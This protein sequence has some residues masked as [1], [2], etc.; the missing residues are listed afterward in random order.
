M[1]EKHKSTREEVAVLEVGHTDVSRPVT[2]WLTL[3]FLAVIALIPL[4]D[5][6]ADMF[7][8]AEGLRIPVAAEIARIAPKMTDVQQALEKHG[9]FKGALRINVRLL[10]G[11]S[12]YESALKDRSLFANTIIPP[13]Q[14]VLIGW[15]QAGSE[16]VYCGH[17]GWLF[18]RPALDSLTGRGFLDP[19]VL[20]TRARPGRLNEPIQPDPVKAIVEFRDYLKARDIRLV[21]LPAPSKATV[22]PE[23]FSSRYDGTRQV[24]NVS[25]GLFLNRLEKA[26]VDVFDPVPLLV[27]AKAEGGVPF[28]LE[29]DTHWSPAGMALT[30]R[31]LARYLN[32]RG[33][34]P[35][36]VKKEYTR[37]AREI[38]HKGDIAAMLR[39]EGDSPYVQPETVTIQRVLEGDGTPWRAEKDAEILVLGDSFTNVFSLEAMGWGDDAGLAP[40]LAAELG[41]P[42]DCIL[43][44]DNAAYATRAELVRQLA[45]GNDRL[46]GKRVVIWEFAARELVIGNWKTGLYSELKIPAS[47]E[48]IHPVT[49]ENEIAQLQIRATLKTVTNVPSPDDIA[50]YTENLSVFEYEVDEVLSGICTFPTLYVAHWGVLD[51]KPVEATLTAAAG[52][53]FTLS[54]ERFEDHPELEGVNMADTVVSDFSIPVLYETSGLVNPAPLENKQRIPMRLNGVVS[55]PTAGSPTSSIFGNFS[56]EEMNS[57][58]EIILQ[59]QERIE[60]SLQRHVNWEEWDAD[61]VDYRNN[62]ELHYAAPDGAPD[63]FKAQKGYLFSRSWDVSYIMASTHGLSEPSPELYMRGVRSPYLVIT[64]LDRIMKSKNI[65]LIVVPVPPRGE[66]NPELL[67]PTKAATV[68]QDGHPGRIRFIKA[69]LENDIEAVDVLPILLSLKNEGIPTS[70]RD[71]SHYTPE[72]ARH[73]AIEVG[74]RIKRYR[75]T[76]DPALKTVHTLE[77]VTLPHKGNTGGPWA[78]Q[79][80]LPRPPDEMISFTRVRGAEGKL[81]KNDETSP[82]LVVG[83]SY[84]YNMQQHSA[85]FRSYLSRELSLP[86]SMHNEGAGGPRAP[87]ILARLKPADLSQLRVVV[88]I[89]AARYLN[90]PSPHNEK[91]I[92][93]T[94]F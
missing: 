6:W 48:D 44:N 2:W 26:G 28:Y 49:K 41:Q 66:V 4:T 16:S 47:V 36:G 67:V 91:W 37:E 89:F 22:Y 20:A 39:Y 12:R 85:D 52:N 19:Q 25:Y 65:H 61:L 62:L 3:M 94:A 70:L 57:R 9:L 51:S 21:L 90:P 73:V 30:A 32:G 55:A 58:H 76:Q 53:T 11:L 56:E 78:E 27:S 71:D 54:L 64:T 77:R 87:R 43:R 29:R 24:Q 83:D 14:E 63:L 45:Q 15:F 13:M 74:R 5:Q 23:R 35:E 69:L 50:P 40:Q 81:V 82:I 72:A 86:V 42:V 84:G 8:G 10:E 92:E 17:D 33:L 34:L 59:D 46:A 1:K 31:H 38:T 68:L 18:Y 60:K 79:N 88:W 93:P 75:F 80:N 7:N